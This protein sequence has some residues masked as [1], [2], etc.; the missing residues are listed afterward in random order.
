MP[1]PIKPTR[2]GAREYDDGSSWMNW[3]AFNR[4]LTEQEESDFI[5]SEQLYTFNNGP[6]SVFAKRPI[7]R[8]TNGHTLL[9]QWGG[10]DI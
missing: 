10:Y 7:F 1:K 4:P 9:I 3:W 8:R 2:C 5:I 6:G